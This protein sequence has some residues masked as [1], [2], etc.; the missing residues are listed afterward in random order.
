MAPGEGSLDDLFALVGHGLYVQRFSGG[1]PSTNGDFSGVAKNSFR[2]ENGKLSDA[3]SEVMI[4]GNLA[5]LLRN[6]IHITAET[7]NDGTSVLP[8]IAFNGITVSGR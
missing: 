4:S 2:I 5:D 6:V 8:W 3:A 1:N 7:A